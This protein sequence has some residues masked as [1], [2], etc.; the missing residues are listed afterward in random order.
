MFEK[1]EIGIPCPKCGHKTDK[2]I[3]WI[4]ANDELVCHGCGSMIRLEKEKLF[5]G[6]KKVDDSIAQLRKSLK[7]IGKRR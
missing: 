3:A 6:L 2:S 4:K 7:G 1:A 5:A